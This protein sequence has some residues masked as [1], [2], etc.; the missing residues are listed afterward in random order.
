MVSSKS[1]NKTIKSG[2]P[3]K[4]GN[5]TIKSGTTTTG[6]IIEQHTMYLALPN[7]YELYEDWI[8]IF[9]SNVSSLT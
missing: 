6:H 4:S 5:K 1:R 8:D 7:F 3:L 9:K 2:T